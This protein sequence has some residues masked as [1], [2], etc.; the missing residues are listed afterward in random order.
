MGSVKIVKK[1]SLRCLIRTPRKK[2]KILRGNDKSHYN[3]NLRKAIMKRSRSKNK[4]PV[5][6][7]NYKKQRNLVVSLNRQAKSQIP[8]AKGFSFW[9]T[10][11]PYF[12]NKHTRGDSNIMLIE[13][14][15]MLPKMK[16]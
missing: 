13:T 8:K 14:D 6:I 7:A 16:K 15:K 4:A 3:K 12:S 10:C 11:K 1:F 9:D 2:V 5:D